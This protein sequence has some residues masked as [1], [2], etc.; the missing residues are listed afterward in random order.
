M[1]KYAPI[2]NNGSIAGL[3]AFAY[4]LIVYYVL[5]SNPLGAWKFLGLAIPALFMYRALVSFRETEGEGKDQVISLLGK[6]TY[7]EMLEYNKAFDLQSLAL[8]DFQSKSLGSILIALI[9][10][11]V[12]KQNPPTFEVSDEQ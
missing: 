5:N 9:V 8:N 2:L 3:A 10:A 12:V 7:E 11:A 4:F 1:K 6:D